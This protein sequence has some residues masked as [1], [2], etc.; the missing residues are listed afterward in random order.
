MIPRKILLLSILAFSC[1]SIS[2]QQITWLTD[3]EQAKTLSRQT[4]KP[5]LYDFTAAWCGPCRRMDRDFW[6]KAEVAALVKDFICVKV[7]FDLEKNFAARYGVNAIPNVVFTDPWGRGLLGQR[8]FGAG[9]EAEILGKIKFLPKDFSSIRDAGNKLEAD[10]KNL[11]SLH[12]FAAFYQE[13]KIYWM[14]NEYYKRLIKV[15]ADAAKRENVLLNIAFNYIRLDEPGDAI[16]T[17]ENLQKE[18]PKSPQNE[19]FLYGLTLA[20]AKKSRHQNANK[21][22]LELKQKFPASKLIEHAEKSVAETIGG[23]K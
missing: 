21:F 5:I 17:F 22:L 15:E 8:G 14:G 11:D 18:Y 19:T 12:Q 10:D 3:L 4:G 7:N 16:D 2:A 23:Q 9:T 13:R 6:P 20:N 1:V